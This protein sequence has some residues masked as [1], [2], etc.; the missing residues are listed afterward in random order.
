MGSQPVS[1]PVAGSGGAGAPAV[2]P[3]QTKTISQ[4]QSMGAQPIQPPSTSTSELN[5]GSIKTTAT[6]YLKNV[7]NQDSQVVPNVESDIQ[8]GAADISKGGAGN[9]VKGVAKAGLRTAGDVAQAVFA[10]ITTALSMAVGQFAHDNPQ[11]AAAY[12]DVIGKI[13]DVVSNSK[14]VQS[15]AVAH[16]NAGADFQRALALAPAGDE[17]DVNQAATDAKTGV[18]KAISSAVN[19]TVQ[20]GTDVVNAINDSMTTTP[21]EKAA[22]QTAQQTQERAKVV[23][24]WTKP[25]IDPSASF[26]KARFVLNKDPEIPNTLVNLGANPI[27]SIEDGKYNTADTAQSIRDNMGQKSAEL[28]RPALQAA[29]ASTPPIEANDIL[30]PALSS[31]ENQPGLTPTMLKAIRAKVGSMISDIGEEYGGQLSLTDQLDEKINHDANAGYNPTKS[32]AD[33]ITAVSNRA[34][35]N[36]LRTTL[37]ENA[38]AGVDVKN[39]NAELAKNYR[40]ADY[41]DALHGKKAPVSLVQS[42]VRYISKIAGARTAG[43]I[44]GGD[45]VSELVGYKVGGALEK[46]VEN[47]TNPMRDAFLK[48]IKSKTSLEAFTKVQNYINSVKESATNI[49]KLPEGQPLGSVKNPI[50]VGPKSTSEAP[51]AQSN[52]TSINPKTGIQ[53][54]RDLKTGKVRIIQK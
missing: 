42:A 14:V 15:F 54:V 29:D 27:A 39:F 50:I 36:G 53:Y 51:A 31:I 45:L 7:F 19:D 18:S 10:P 40:A 33:N 4:L 20:K 24:D 9:I 16:P 8:A 1:T 26:D 30:A 2:A 43:L 3:T 5:P 37:E 17:S 34:V 28:L 38:P 12:N 35:A 13:S 41:L 47:M 32:D 44:G 21:E 11:L 46:L 23:S 49:V 48:D 6:D 25:T 52:S 22:A